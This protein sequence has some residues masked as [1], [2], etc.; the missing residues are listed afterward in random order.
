M[1][2]VKPAGATTLYIYILLFLPPPSFDRRSTRVTT[3]VVR[4]P[5][6]SEKLWV[7]PKRWRFTNKPWQECFIAAAPQAPAQFSAVLSSR[8]LALALQTHAHT[9]ILWWNPFFRP[10][11]ATIIARKQLFSRRRTCSDLCRWS[12]SSSLCY[13]F[14]IFIYYYF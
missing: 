13:R 14:F 7:G 1:Q 9:M 6:V 10:L 8:R 2:K 3:V 4:F 12:N 5:S 11:T